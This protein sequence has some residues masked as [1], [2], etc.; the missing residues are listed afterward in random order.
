MTARHDRFWHLA[1]IDSDG[2]HVRFL[3]ESGHRM[4]LRLESAHDPRQTSSSGTTLGSYRSTAIRTGY[5]GSLLICG[6]Y[7]FELD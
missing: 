7:T 5:D 4:E 6:R 2:A 1:D 3:G